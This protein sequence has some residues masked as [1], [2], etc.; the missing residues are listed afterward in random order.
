MGRAALVVPGSGG[1]V[2]HARRLPLPVHG[3]HQQVAPEQE[4]VVHPPRGEIVLVIEDERALHG[5]AGLAGV[6]ER[7]VEIRHQAVAPLNRAAA[8]RFHRLPD[9]PGILVILAPVVVVAK[10]RR[11]RTVLIPADQQF[12]RGVLHEATHV[13]PDEGLAADT[14]AHR[15]RHAHPQVFPARAIVAQPVRGVTPDAG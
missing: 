6:H 14:E 1:Q 5:R 2:D 9:H 13:C 12:R 8:D 3:G 7:G 11:Q 10:E 4:L 15:H